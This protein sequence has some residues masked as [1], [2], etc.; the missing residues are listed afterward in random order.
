MTASPDVSNSTTRSVVT[1]IVGWLI[2]AIVA[3]W[4]LDAVVGTVRFFVRV[5]IW[6][7]ILGGLLYAYARLKAGADDD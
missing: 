3:F 2:V 5:V 1:S 6:I 7:A 4:L